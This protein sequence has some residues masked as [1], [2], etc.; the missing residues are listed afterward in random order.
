MEL[1]ERT[2]V[3]S[4]YFRIAWIVL[5]LF[6]LCV[7]VHQ[8]L[9]VLPFLNSDQ[10]ISLQLQHSSCVHFIVYLESLD[11]DTDNKLNSHLNHAC[12]QHQV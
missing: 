8:G 10:N 2:W 11:D 1:A 4:I 6:A 9:A 12:A 5:T 3:D 7:V